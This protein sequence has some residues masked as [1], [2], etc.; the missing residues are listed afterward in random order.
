MIS[1]ELTKSVSIG[2]VPR[3]PGSVLSLPLAFGEALIASG[4][5]IATCPDGTCGIAPPPEEKP[6]KGRKPVIDSP[7]G[8][9]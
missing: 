2:G 4:S 7:E 1:V 8:S 9:E 5:A 6:R 3:D